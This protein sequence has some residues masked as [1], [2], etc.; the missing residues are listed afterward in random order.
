MDTCP[1]G[2]GSGRWPLSGSVLGT[3]FNVRTKH[4]TGAAAP[5][6]SVTQTRVPAQLG[7]REG[8]P[9]RVEAGGGSQPRLSS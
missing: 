5:A 7:C 2:L 9:G 4:A 1:L 3:W 6:C 8:S